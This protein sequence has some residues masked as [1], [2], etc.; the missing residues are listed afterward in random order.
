MAGMLDSPVSPP[1]E[2]AGALYAAVRLFGRFWIWFFFKTVDVRRP[3]RVPASGPVILCINHPNNLID[4]LLVGAVLSRKVHFLATAALFR[5]ALVRRFLLAC[6][7]IPVYRKQEDPDKMDRNVDAFAACFDTIARGGLIGIYP[8]GTTHAEPRV[9]HIKTGAARIALEGEARRAAAGGA[10]PSL[11]LV[12]VGLNFEARKSFRGR[13]LVSFGEPIGIASRLARF[14]EDAVKAVE[15]LTADIQWGMEAEVVSV[16]RINS[17]A[18][19]RAVEDLYRGELVRELEE[20]RGLSP[21]QIDTFRLSRGIAEATAHFEEREPERIEGLW[22]RIRAYRGLLDSYRVKDEAVRARVRRPDRRGRIRTSGQASVGFPIFVY[23][24]AVNGAPYVL[25]R[26][27]ARRLAH[28]ETDYATTRLLASIVAVP[29]FW[30]VETWIVWRTAGVFVGGWWASL[31][32]LAFFLSLPVSGVLAMRY[33]RG[34]G[35]VRSQLQLGV[36]SLTRRQAASRLIEE[37]RG[38]IAEFE[39]AKNDYLAATRG[40]TF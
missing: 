22:Q 16:K 24:M 7:A 31:V 12:P 14:R 10:G 13:V 9:Q 35:R 27:V 5:N 21:R 17:A 15:T 25:T 30:G 6:G 28:K 39:R 34:A 4:S 2:R 23:G 33:L 19:I 18:F 26:W 1:R 20:E 36:L 8:E 38:L 11:T 29:L 3:E 40:S 32:A 37:R